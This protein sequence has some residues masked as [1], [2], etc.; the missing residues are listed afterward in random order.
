MYR[1][2]M[3]RKRIEVM[4]CDWHS[5]TAEPEGIRRYRIEYPDGR[6]AWDL[7]AAHAADLMPY[8]LLKPNH[9]KTRNTDDMFVTT[10]EEQIVRA[11]RK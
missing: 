2:H 6:V 5:C 10:T 8:R 1:C 7:C 4:T 11:R 9:Q 3:G